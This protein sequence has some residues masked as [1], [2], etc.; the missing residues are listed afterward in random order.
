MH[1]ATCMRLV[2][3]RTSGS[4]R[5][6][7]CARHSPGNS[8]RSQAT[9]HRSHPGSLGAG[10]ASGQ[11]DG[12]ACELTPEVYPEIERTFEWFAEILRTGLRPSL[13]VA[14]GERLAEDQRQVVVQRTAG[15]R[16]HEVD[17]PPD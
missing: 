2:N 15:V 4:F 10:T 8:P 14:V 17:Q 5:I 12:T 9:A 6:T 3:A 1:A 11:S 7:S 16:D 13:G